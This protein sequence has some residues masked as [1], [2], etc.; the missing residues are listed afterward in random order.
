MAYRFFNTIIDDLFAF[1]VKLPL[2]YRIA[3]FRDDL[4]FLVYIYQKWIYRNNK[5]I[6]IE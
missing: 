1:S 5:T 3:V 6:K 2:L 4:I